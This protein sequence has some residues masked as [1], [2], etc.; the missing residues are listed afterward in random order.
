ML[1]PTAP[2]RPAPAAATRHGPVIARSAMAPRGAGLFID[3]ALGLSSAVAPVAV[4]VDTL[5]RPG[6][7]LRAWRAFAESSGRPWEAMR[8]IWFSRVARELLYAILLA[9]GKRA[10][11]DR[12]AVTGNTT[13]LDRGCVLAI[14]H[15]P[16]GRLLA[17][18]I[19]R[20]SRVAV[21]ATRRW[22]A[23]APGAHEPA[24]AR[25]MRRAIARL[26][27]GRCVAITIDHF[28]PCDGCDATILR[29][30]VQV[31]TGAARIAAR[32]GVP[33]AP[34]VVRHVGGRFEIA[35]GEEVPVSAHTAEGVT[36]A[37]IAALDHAITRDPSIW[38]D[39]LRFASRP[40]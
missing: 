16:W 29:R 20:D 25:G 23:R 37:A 28:D 34:A 13:M 15:S 19:S 2:G 33:L 8:G 3:A 36:R 40:R 18:W 17:A 7:A 30:Q 22:T 24:T 14:C 4:M 32:A 9:G 38:A 31:C 26:R 11:L 6:R 39:A 21:L 35:I 1:H 5:L 12:I 27:E 10:L